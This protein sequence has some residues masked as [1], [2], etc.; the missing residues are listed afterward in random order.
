MRILATSDLHGYLPEITEK[1]DLLLICGDVT[2]G[3]FH[4]LILEQYWMKNRFVDWI[5]SLPFNDESSK[6]VMTWGNHD[7]IGERSEADFD[8]SV[9][10]LTHGRL[11]ILKHE[12]FDFQGI[13]I[14][15]TPYCSIFY[16]W[17]FMINDEA[18]DRKF[19]QIPEGVDILISHDS[20]TTNCLGSITQGRYKDDTTGNKVLA[21]H[22]ERIKPK[23]FFSGHFH[24]G[25]HNFEE[26][27][28]TWMA[29]VSLMDEMYSPTNKILSFLF[30]ATNKS[31][32][33]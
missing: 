16:N 18:L 32:A 21:K 27:N 8:R 15:G 31:V 30:D 33:L 4:N 14:F 3:N 23:L 24:S 7:F 28:G 9:E 25:N 17:A 29:N 26:V 20:P 10:E 1:F 2:P 22:L 19:S 12:M 5:L 11:K 13:S 6:V